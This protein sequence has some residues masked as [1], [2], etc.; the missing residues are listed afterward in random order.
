MLNKNSYITINKKDTVKKAAIQE[1]SNF[2]NRAQQLY[3]KY[4]KTMKILENK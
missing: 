1:N 3:Q 4:S 2:T